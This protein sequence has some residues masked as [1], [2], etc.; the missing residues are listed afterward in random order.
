M[1]DIEVREEDKVIVT[2]GS[3][4]EGSS[5]GSMDS[6][7]ELNGK[8]GQRRLETVGEDS[9]WQSRNSV[10]P[11]NFTEHIQQSQVGIFHHDTS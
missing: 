7:P 2:L 9:S 1:K 11:E 8:S 6:A 4:V 5:L 10:Y 3:M